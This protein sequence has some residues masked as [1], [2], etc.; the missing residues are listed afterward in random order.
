MQELLNKN[1]ENLFFIRIRLKQMLRDF[2]LEKATTEEVQNAL[3]SIKSLTIG[4]D[5]MGLEMLNYCCTL[6]I[7]VITYL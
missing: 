7:T 5:K 3:Y 6:I 1:R 4:N 2:I